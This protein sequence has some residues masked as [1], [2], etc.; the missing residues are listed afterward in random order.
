MALQT[1][2][3]FTDPSLTI[4]V[5]GGINFSHKSDGS[6]G[7]VTKVFYIGSPSDLSVL[8]T[9]VNPGV[10]QI[11]MSATDPDGSAGTPAISNIKMALD[12]TSLDT[13]NAGDPL[14]IGAVINGGIA[15][16]V[17]IYIRASLPAGE[18]ALNISTNDLTET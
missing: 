5:A 17:P 8:T 2:N 1:F 11:I 14:S 3:I 4:I 13:V 15:N 7:D 10:D 18:G 16:A 6:T 12:L 9:T